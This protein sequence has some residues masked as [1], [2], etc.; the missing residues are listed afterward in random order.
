MIK[1]YKRMIYDKKWSTPFV[2]RIAVL[3]DRDGETGSKIDS[4]A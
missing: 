4:N 2:E 1:L 3:V